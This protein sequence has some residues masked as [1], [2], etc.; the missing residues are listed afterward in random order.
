MRRVVIFD[1]AL[2]PRAKGQGLRSKGQAK[3]TRLGLQRR[4]TALSPTGR[5]VPEAFQPLA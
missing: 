5:P 2:A 3:D 1:D 4:D